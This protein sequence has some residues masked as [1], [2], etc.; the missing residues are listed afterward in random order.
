MPVTE[1][2]VAERP[3]IPPEYRATGG[4]AS[5]TRTGMG[6]L[7]AATAAAGETGAAWAG[8]DAASR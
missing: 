5:C 1:G 2:A 3:A 6:R 4:S 8:I 7:A